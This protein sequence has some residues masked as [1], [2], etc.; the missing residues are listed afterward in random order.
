MGSGPSGI[1]AGA[2]RAFSQEADACTGCSFCV[3][4]SPNPLLCCGLCSMNF[5]L[6]LIQ[7]FLETRMLEKGFH[8]LLLHRLTI[9]SNM[10]KWPRSSDFCS[11]AGM[12]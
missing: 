3:S 4:A 8:Y 12:L 2:G 10:K 1:L 11:F 7:S 5:P 9:Y 6:I